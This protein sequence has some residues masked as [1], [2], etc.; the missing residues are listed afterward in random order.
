MSDTNVAV[1]GGTVTA[2][3]SRQNVGAKGTV[4]VKFQIQNTTGTGTYAKIQYLQVQ[5]WG[6]VADAVFP[7]LRAG[8]RVIA[9]GQLQLNNWTGQ[10][11]QQHNDWILNAQQ[12]EL[13]KAAPDVLEPHED[14]EVATF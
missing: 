12:I 7:N 8:A 11:G 3:A 4:L 10:D 2:P 13:T 1:M 14:E 9:T 6:Q 5:A